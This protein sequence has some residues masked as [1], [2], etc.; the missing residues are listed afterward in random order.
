M[1]ARELGL[2]QQESST[3]AEILERTGQRIDASHH[4]ANRGSV[5]APSVRRDLL[6]DVWEQQSQ[7]NPMDV[8]F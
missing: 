3:I 7:L 1:N 6:A 8:F 5:I 2:T 4:R